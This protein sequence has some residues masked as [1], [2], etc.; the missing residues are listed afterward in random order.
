MSREIINPES[1]L[2]TKKYV[3]L[4]LSL[5]EPLNVAVNSFDNNIFSIDGYVN[6]AKANLKKVMII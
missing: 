3:D 4:T 1:L 5:L 6:S 2:N